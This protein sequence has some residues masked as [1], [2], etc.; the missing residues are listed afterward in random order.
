MKDTR[1]TGV[2]EAAAQAFEPEAPSQPQAHVARPEAMSAKDYDKALRRLHA[3]LVKM[4]EWVVRKG[5]KV[6]IVFEGPDGAS[7][8]GTASWRAC[9]WWS[10]SLGQQEEGAPEHHQPHPGA[11]SVHGD[12]AREDRPSQATEARRVPRVEMRLQGYSGQVLKP[13]PHAAL[14]STAHQGESSRRSVHS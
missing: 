13:R 8:G 2:P 11:A 3:E 14:F 12:A 10:G 9:P 6:C 4:Q 7:K 5:L 1:K